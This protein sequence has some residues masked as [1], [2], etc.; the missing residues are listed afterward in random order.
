MYYA[1]PEEPQPI[2]NVA[3]P[4]LLTPSFSKTLFT[5]TPITTTTIII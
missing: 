4:I 3:T 5:T 1:K 2:K